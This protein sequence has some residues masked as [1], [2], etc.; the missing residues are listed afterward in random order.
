M[1]S[2]VSMRGKNTRFEKLNAH[3]QLR[4]LWQYGPDLERCGAH[5]GGGGRCQAGR[6]CGRPG[7]RGSTPLRLARPPARSGSWRCGNGV[8]SGHSEWK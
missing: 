8:L 1:S 5:G 3:V 4:C 2:L 6:G 7:A